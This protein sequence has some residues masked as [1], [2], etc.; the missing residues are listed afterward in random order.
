MAPMAT[1][2]VTQTRKLRMLGTPDQGWHELAVGGPGF[3]QGVAFVLVG[4]GFIC[5]DVSLKA[6]R[7]GGAVYRREAAAALQPTTS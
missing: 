1:P 4:P 5:L 3:V 2:W 6:A 7:D